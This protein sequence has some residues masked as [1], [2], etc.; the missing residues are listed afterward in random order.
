[1]NLQITFLDKSIDLS[2]CLGM[3]M[4][5]RYPYIQFAT[6]NSSTISQHS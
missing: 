1:M 4:M 6:Q 5:L 2:P 3:W